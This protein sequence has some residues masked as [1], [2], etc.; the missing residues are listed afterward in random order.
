MVEQESERM[1]VTF[2]IKGIKNYD[3]AVRL[4]AMVDWLVD[5]NN[6]DRVETTSIKA[7]VIEGEE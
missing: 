2:E 6:K 7:N 5:P 4:G 3:E 1:K